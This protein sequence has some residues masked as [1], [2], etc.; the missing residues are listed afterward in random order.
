ME[1]ELL[2]CRVYLSWSLYTLLT[3]TVGDSCLSCFIPCHTCNLCGA[4]LKFCLFLD[5]ADT[6]RRSIS[7]PSQVNNTSTVTAALVPPIQLQPPPERQS[8]FKLKPFS[9][10]SF[11]RSK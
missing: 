6:V 4:L 8:A 10:L 2:F 5:V 7:F 3:I 11:K 9:K 1:E